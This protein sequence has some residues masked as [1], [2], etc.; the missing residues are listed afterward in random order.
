[1]IFA[2]QQ[3]ESEAKKIW[4][5]SQNSSSKAM[6]NDRVEG[7]VDPHTSTGSLIKPLS[8]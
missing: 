2:D 6:V 3:R 5:G 8:K 4:G 1:M 7:E